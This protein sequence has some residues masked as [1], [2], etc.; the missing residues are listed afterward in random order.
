MNLPSFLLD[1]PSLEAE[2]MLNATF[3]TVVVPFH[4]AGLIPDTEL[5]YGFED[6]PI[7]AEVAVLLREGARRWH[8][9]EGKATDF[10]V[11]QRGFVQAF[12]S[13]LH[14]AIQLH[15]REGSRMTASSSLAGLFEGRSE[16]AVGSPLTDWA[17][18]HASI[19]EDVFTTFQDQTLAAVGSTR[20]ETLFDDFYAC[21]CLWAA[22]AGGEAGLAQMAELVE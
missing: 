15:R 20:N 13:G 7:L 9:V 11:L 12:R 3:L 19:I 18:D 14:I 2:N 21:G 10:R 16:W 5:Q 1:R 4:E 17:K 6:L 8:T 22:L